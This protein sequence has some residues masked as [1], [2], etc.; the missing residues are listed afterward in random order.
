MTDALRSSTTY[1]SIPM[2][3][4]SRATKRRAEHIPAELHRFAAPSGPWP[5][6][7]T[8][9]S[10]LD[11]P[12]RPDRLH[13]TV[14]PDDWS[15]YPPS[16]YP[17]WTRAVCEVSGIQS[18]L[19]RPD[20]SE[21]AVYTI[22]VMH[23]ND[24]VLRPEMKGVTTSELLTEPLKDPRPPEVTVRC[25][26]ME[27]IS[28][29]VLQ[30]IGATYNVEPFYWSSA[31]NGIPS[32]YKEDVDESDGGDHLTIILP[33]VRSVDTEEY[34]ETLKNKGNKAE[35]DLAIE[36]QKPL[37]LRSGNLAPAKPDSPSF[38]SDEPTRAPAE[39]S[40]SPQTLIFDVLAV[41]LVRDPALPTLLSYHPKSK[42]WL[43]TSAEHMYKRV[44]MAGD[45][46]YWGRIWRNSR[47]PTFML[48]IIMWHALY[49]WDEAM[50][51]LFDAIV[52]AETTA[53]DKEKVGEIEITHEL[54][55]IRS[56]L[57]LY[58]RRLKDFH[59]SVDFILKHPN[60]AFAG[61]SPDMLKSQGLMTRECEYLLSEVERLQ[62]T[63]DMCQQRV[64]NTVELVY[65]TLTVRDSTS[66]EMQAWVSQQVTYLTTVFLPPTF[67]ATIFGM[68]ISILSDDTHGKLSEYLYISIPFIA[69]TAWLM[70]ALRRHLRYPN[71]LFVSQLLW[72]FDDL[73]AMYRKLRRG[74][75]KATTE[76]ELLERFGRTT[77]EVPPE[78]K[79]HGWAVIKHYMTRQNSRA[80][81]SNSPRPKPIDIVVS[82]SAHE[83][84]FTV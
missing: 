61:D 74:P 52:T 56:A 57:L 65:H 8:R 51:S 37:K 82:T 31:L 77:E 15:N 54:H 34:E 40:S 44:E 13:P 69:I 39:T 45:G 38:F 75:P 48:L 18:L 17:N 58:H 7:S 79:P 55:G 47:D 63:R 84:H 36:L 20:S 30:K 64:D 5:W 10:K 83:Q 60:P 33:F 70:M 68:N 25:L 28:G 62:D 73:R 26:F 67:I 81:P 19:E 72:P 80:T 12:R 3:P 59:N 11:L 71:G 21:T 22:D 78:T 35:Y 43:T 16:H 46:I 41:H 76:E 50:D 42:Y 53:K 2:R 66:S 4:R 1:S 6:R 29:N 9:I 49:A 32:R 24:F 23:N 27:D 14:M